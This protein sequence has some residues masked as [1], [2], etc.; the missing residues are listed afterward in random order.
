M[1]TLIILAIVVV[2]VG[3]TLVVVT[4]GIRRTIAAND[5]QL[6]ALRPTS[7]GELVEGARVRVIGTANGPELVK[8]PYTGAPC[9]A[10][11][12]SSS[13][14][15][16]GGRTGDRTVQG[17]DTRDVRPFTVDDGTG[18][19]AVDIE[20]VTLDLA[21]HLATQEDIQR[22]VFGAKLLARDTAGTTYWEHILEPATKVA[23][24]GQVVR[25][26]DGALRMVGT[27][28]SPLVVS[29]HDAALRVAQ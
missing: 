27:A 6:Q 2:F 17:P 20:H 22:H 21:V 25:G 4:A 12:G 1:S 29:N 11:H 15:I 13:A 28:Q 3:V 9:L 10:F 23:V 19:I 8:A 14:R 24:I 16:E 7:I 18:T 5:A 26:G